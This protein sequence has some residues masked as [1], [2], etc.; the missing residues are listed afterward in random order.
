MGSDVCGTFAV[1]HEQ[2]QGRGVAP[3]RPS[4][5][6]VAVA[7]RPC[8]GVSVFRTIFGCLSKKYYVFSVFPYNII[9]FVC[10][11]HAFAFH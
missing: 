8:A 11:A 9:R 6:A 7:V 10:F 5:E 2:E 3:V 4:P 1:T